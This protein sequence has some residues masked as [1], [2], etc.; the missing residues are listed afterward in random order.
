[1]KTTKPLLLAVACLLC[2]TANAQ[3]VKGRVYFGSVSQ[4]S[5]ES[6]PGQNRLSLGVTK[7][8]TEYADGSVSESKESAF[9]FSVFGGYFFVNRLMGGISLSYYWSKYKSETSGYNR[10]N[11]TISAS[12]MIRYYFTAAGTIRPFAS[13][14]TGISLSKTRNTQPAFPDSESKYNDFS[15]SGEVGAQWLLNPQVALEASV[16]FD[17][18]RLKFENTEPSHYNSLSLSLGLGFFL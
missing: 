2:V 7:H 17:R 10:T 6:F 4:I 3:M 1:M 14:K 8:K 13:L 16:I 5:G 18:S 11:T 12:P 9:N 15:W